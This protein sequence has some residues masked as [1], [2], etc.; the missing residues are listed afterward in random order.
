MENNPLGNVSENELI[1]SCSYNYIP[2]KTEYD[3]ITKISFENY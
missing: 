2:R 3:F 1:I